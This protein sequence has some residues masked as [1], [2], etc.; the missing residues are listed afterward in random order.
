MAALSLHVTEWH[1]EVVRHICLFLFLP[2]G[3]KKHRITNH[4]VIHNQNKKNNDAY[5]QL[6]QLM[7]QREEEE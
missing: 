3:S 2:E 4:H 1:Q 5:Q 7:I 6:Q